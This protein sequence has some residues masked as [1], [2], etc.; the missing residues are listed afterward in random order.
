M[1]RRTFLQVIAGSFL[2]PP[3][4]AEAQLARTVRIGVLLF[5]TPATDPNLPTLRDA[6]RRLGW[7]EGGNLALEYRYAE[8]RV[9]R[10]SQYAAELVQLKPDLIYPL[11]GDVAPFAKSAT[12]TVLRLAARTREERAMPSDWRG[13]VR[14]TSI[15]W[16]VWLL[17]ALGVLGYFAS[18]GLQI[19]R[20]G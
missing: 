19:L 6:L 15:I 1:R 7:R 14:F 10:L 17:L 11:G 8:G 2:P 20:H 9:E 18:L 13:L 3:L 5:S 16:V 4:P 12:S